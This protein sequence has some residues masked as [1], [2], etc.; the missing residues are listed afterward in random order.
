MDRC[1]PAICCR[2]GSRPGSGGIIKT[3]YVLID[4]ESVQPEI[5]AALKDDHYR[6]LMFIGPTQARI[7]INVATALQ[8]LGTRAEYIRVS[9]PGRNA[10]DFHI[11]YYLGRLAVAEPDAYFH[12]ISVDKGYDPLIEHL[13][14]KGVHA[15]RCADVND[16]PIVRTSGTAPAD[17]K[18]SSI[19]AYLVKR[20]EQRPA[21]TKTLST[22][23]AALFQPKLDEAEV[24]LLLAEL[25]RNGVFVVNGTK[26][27]YSLPD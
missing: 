26:V 16:I 23:V 6:V 8:V 3:N 14:S 13:K 27:V 10:L 12:V 22:S 25:Q 2:L 21:S 17:D 19:L 15:T 18:L 9:A 4:Y 5:V 7:D 1:R 24:Q 20:G 11:A